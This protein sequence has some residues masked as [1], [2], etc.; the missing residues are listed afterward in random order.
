MSK[1]DTGAAAGLAG[2]AG[3]AVALAVA[4]EA[5]LADLERRLPLGMGP[6]ERVEAARIREAARRLV[7]CAGEIAA[8]DGFKLAVEALIPVNRQSGSNVGVIG[9]LHFY[10]DDLDPRGIGRPIFATAQPAMRRN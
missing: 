6:L 4:A 1:R 2:P 10:L 3:G 5:A 7:E 9:Q 8:G